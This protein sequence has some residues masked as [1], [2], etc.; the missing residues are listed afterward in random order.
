M[1][2]KKSVKNEEIKKEVKKTNSLKT[3]DKVIINNDIKRVVKLVAYICTFFATVFALIIFVFGI[4]STL[5]IANS[6]KEEL[7]SN[8]FA[9]TFVS[10]IS[11]CSSFDTKLAIKNMESRALFIIS[12]VILPIIALICALVLIVLLANIILK[13][14]EENSK[15]SEIF[16]K[17]NIIILEKFINILSIII[18]ITWG[19][20]NEP[21]LLFILMIYFLLFIIF[22][23]FKRNVELHK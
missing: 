14:I 20:F 6:S 1:E 16:D 18:F 10:K 8:N 12:E 19:L 11:N 22:I 15:E 23:L 4:I 13:F 17:K 7:L 5:S 3:T 9:I 21:S 2:K